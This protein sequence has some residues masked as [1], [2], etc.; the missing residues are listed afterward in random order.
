MA[1]VN[2]V[3]QS[4]SDKNEIFCRFRDFVCKRNGTYDYSTTGIGWTLIDSSYATDEDNCTINDWFVIYSPGEGGK[5]DLYIQVKWIDNL[6]GLYGYQAWDATTHAGSTN[7][8]VTGNAWT[9]AEGITGPFWIYGDLDAV[10]GIHYLS[11]VDYRG[12]YFGKLD[13]GYYDLTG[14]IATCG[15]TLT[16]GS[17]VSIVVDSAPAEWAVGREIF[18]RTIHN[19]DMGT[20]KCEKIEIK[21]LVSNT[22]TADLVNSYTIGSCLSNHIGYWAF[23]TSNFGVG[24]TLIGP[25]GTNN[26]A[27]AITYTDFVTSYFDPEK[28]ESRYLLMDF[29]QQSSN[30]MIGV[31]KHIKKSTSYG[32]V[33]PQLTYQDILEETDGTQWRTFKIYSNN[34]IA[35]KEV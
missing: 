19:D 5:D 4:A 7:K 11:S 17:D 18:I 10:M 20:V 22:I 12:C 16:A 32:T 2:L 8:Y 33:L 15:T 14:E 25:D 13:P 1:Y 21:T 26:Y 31:M 30:G 23:N 24:N 29:Y 9:T 3:D 34:Y 28:Y 6:I 27:T 35:I